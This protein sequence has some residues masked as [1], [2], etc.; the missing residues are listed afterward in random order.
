MLMG[1]KCRNK[2]PYC[3]YSANYCKNILYAVPYL[4]SGAGTIATI[5]HFSFERMARKGIPD[6]LSPLKVGKKITSKI[7]GMAAI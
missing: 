3:T 7:Y 4:F 1:E 6:V 5:Y 2:E